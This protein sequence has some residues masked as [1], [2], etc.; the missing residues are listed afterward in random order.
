MLTNSRPRDKNARKDVTGRSARSAQAIVDEIKADGGRAVEA[1]GDAQDEAGM[2]EILRRLEAIGP[3][4]VGIYSIDAQM[5]SALTERAPG[6]RISRVQ[7]Q[8]CLMSLDVS[9]AGADHRRVSPVRA[10]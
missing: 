7:S 3:V 1:V 4:E 10:S 8:R 6:P 2:L 9:P 5:S